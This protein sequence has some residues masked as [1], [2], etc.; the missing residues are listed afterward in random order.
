[1]TKRFCHAGWCLAMMLALSPRLTQADQ[2]AVAASSYRNTERTRI[3]ERAERSSVNIHTEKRQKSMDVVF[4]AGKATKINGMGTGI[5]ID[6][7]GYIVTN[8]HVVQDVER[9]RCTTYNGAEY[10][11]RVLAYDSRE[12]LAIIKIEPRE[13]LTVAN[14]GTSSDLMLGEDVIAIGNA[15]G[16]ESSVTRGIISHRSRDVEVNDEQ[17]YK[18][19]IQ[20]DAAINP[21]NSG[22]PLLNADGEVIGINVAIR[23][24]AQRI[25]FAI[26]ID[27]ARR[28][29]ARLMNVER[30]NLTYHGIQT[31]DMK[32]GLDRKLVVQAIRPDSP[33]LAAGLKSG[34]IITKAGDVTVVDGA[35]FERS[36]FGKPAGS[37]VSVIVQREGKEETLHLRVAE[38]ASARRTPATQGI[39]ASPV[40]TVANNTVAPQTTIEKCWE[41]L[42]LKLEKADQ[43]FPVPGQPYRGGM[44]VVSVR[45]QSQADINGIRTGDILVGLHIWETVSNENIEFVLNHPQ[46]Q[47]LGPLK[48][49]I[50][51]EGETLFG[52]FRLVAGQK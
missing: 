50:V 27:D 20:I 28:V 40:S 48:F 38:L 45:P 13:P 12:D 18:D 22:G 36:M 9:L 25:G 43:G 4:S 51:R 31:T 5:V 2:P 39:P 44:R 1:M 41:M 11:G 32:Q 49:Y 47:T 21:G 23:A 6:E 46:L 33:A 19:L 3:V 8:F 16:Y 26:P 24:G 35:D 17:S 29:I 42:G 10:E 34:D 37:D 15:Y 52:H 30:H 7:R 14:F